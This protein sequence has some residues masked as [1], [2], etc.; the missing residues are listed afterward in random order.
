M[1]FKG[2]EWLYY[3]EE[4]WL[5]N[6]EGI[7]DLIKTLHSTALNEMIDLFFNKRMSGLSIDRG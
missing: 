3:T 5:I 6:I 7:I 4:Y 1:Y 2:A